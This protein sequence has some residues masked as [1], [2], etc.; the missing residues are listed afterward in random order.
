QQVAPLVEVL[1]GLPAVGTVPPVLTARPRLGVHE[2]DAGPRPGGGDGGG[3]A[4]RSRADD[5]D[6]TPAGRHG[7]PPAGSGRRGRRPRTR[8]SGPRTGRWSG[9]YGRKPA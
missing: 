2:D 4:R 6:V 8:G 3:G 1:R 7:P 9:Q 5:R